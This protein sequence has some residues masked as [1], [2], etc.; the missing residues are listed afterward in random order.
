[1]PPYPHVA[2]HLDITISNHKK[3]SY[4]HMCYCILS[5][6]C[7]K[8]LHY[9]DTTAQASFNS[10]QHKWLNKVKIVQV[11]FN[12]DYQMLAIPFFILFSWLS[13]NSLIFSK[14]NSNQCVGLLPI[15]PHTNSLCFPNTQQFSLQYSISSNACIWWWSLSQ[16]SESILSQLNYL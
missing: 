12:L 10:Y 4:W 15:Y 11:I 13:F 7:V 16:R 14:T 9:L 2:S 8:I 3:V 6:Y 5:F 1:M